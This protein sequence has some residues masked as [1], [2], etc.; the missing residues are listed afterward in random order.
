M[1]S[2][3]RMAVESSTGGTKAADGRIGRSYYNQSTYFDPSHLS[4]FDSRFQRYRIRKVLELCA[5]RPTDKALDLG[6]G[7][8]TISFAL[9]PKV[10]EVVGLDYAERA[11]ANC[12][13]RLAKLGLE[14][15]S[16]RVGDGRDSHLDTASFDLVVAADLFE[17]IY[18]EDSEAV[19]E[20]A[21]R[22]L[23]PGG[24]FAVWTPCR[25][26]VIE[27]LKN[28]D[29][30]LKRDV[31]HVD[32]KS[33]PR[34]K[35]ILERAGFVIERAFFAESHLPGLMVVERLAQRWLPLLRRRIAVLAI[36][37]GSPSIKST[38]GAARP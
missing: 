8:G 11:V 10:N 21:F 25:S 38:G 7:W 29:V 16:F 6:C 28:N 23:R 12:N 9:G 35:G 3:P 15:V 1:E 32:Y 4:D 36:K 14:N 19:A 20:E 31:T 13:A 22:V 37:P 27:I 26:H 24:R 33:M 2:E 18:P 5:P 30:L 34:M 17:H